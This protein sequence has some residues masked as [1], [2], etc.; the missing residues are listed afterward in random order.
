MSSLRFTSM[1]GISCSMFLTG[2]LL[3]EYCAFCGE[4]ESCLWNMN[5]EHQSIIIKPLTL[6]SI[7]NTVPIFVFGYNCHPSVFP[8]YKSMVKDKGDAGTPRS[9]PRMATVF[10]TALSFSVT[11]YTIAGASGFLLLLDDVPGNIL[12]YEFGGRPHMILAKI[13]FATAMILAVPTFVNAI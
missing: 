9:P 1:A 3:Y 7:V 5:P 13:L 8:I 6:S 11:A 4:R 12:E 10:K 2:C